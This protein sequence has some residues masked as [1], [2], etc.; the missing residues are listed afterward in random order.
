MS[1]RSSD[2]ARLS[3]SS[4]LFKSRTLTPEEL[5]ATPTLLP[6]ILEQIQ[7]MVRMLRHVKYGDYVLA[8]DPNKIIDILARFDRFNQHVAYWFTKRNVRLPQDVYDKISIISAKVQA[9]NRPMTG[10]IIDVEPWNTITE[11]LALEYEVLK[12]LAMTFQT[13]RRTDTAKLAT[14][15]SKTMM[16]AATATL[17]EKA[18]AIIVKLT[19][20]IYKPDSR[21]PSTASP[22]NAYSRTPSAVSTM[23]PYSRMPSTLSAFNT[24]TRLPNTV[25]LATPFVEVEGG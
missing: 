13:F 23:E 12:A 25:T 8:D 11:I 10:D 16:Q 9:L 3:E 19:A 2:T 21:M 20:E 22:L 17:V 4:R 1:Y 5:E 18:I 14:T 15:A 24:Y 6:G 7:T